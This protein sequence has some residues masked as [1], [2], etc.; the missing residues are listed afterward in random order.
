MRVSFGDPFDRVP[1]SLGHP[2]ERGPMSRSYEPTITE[3]C[4]R[5]HC[6]PDQIHTLFADFG[7]VPT[8]LEFLR[9]G[10]QAIVASRTR[11]LVW[12][13]STGIDAD[14]IADNLALSSELA[15][16]AP[17][18]GPQ[19]TTVATA[20]A[21]CM[22]EW[23]LGSPVPAERA[24]T[25]LGQCLVGLHSHAVPAGLPV[26]GDFEKIPGRL[27]R[28]VAQDVPDDLLNRMQDR[29][30][31]VVPRM[32]AVV[33]QDR[34]LMHG[35]AHIGNLVELDGRPLLI[36]LD[37]LSTGPHQLDLVPSWVSGR[38][39]QRDPAQFQHLIDAYGEDVRQWSEFDTACRYRELTMNTWL[40]TLWDSSEHARNELR[41][42]LATWDTPPDAHRPWTAL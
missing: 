33:H 7:R 42:R 30:D 11:G 3:I 5:L 21:L 26:F 27:E 15:R 14:A 28:A 18:L 41:H 32:R 40:A 36:D 22:S 6:E 20:G 1:R 16:T 9:H 31:Q 8:D 34:T 2:R 10:T 37:D 4:H 25:S 39:M 13:I 29:A 12:R 35:D 38:R 19:R 23:R 17:V 24:F